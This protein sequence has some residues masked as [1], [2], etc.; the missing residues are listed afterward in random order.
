MARIRSLKP[1]FCKSES[2]AA[3][4]IPCRLHFAMLWTY[5]DDA[6]RGVDNPR[7]I[8]GELW[9][10]DDAVDLD[11]I[12]R[13]QDELN[14]KGKI[15]RYRDGDKRYFEVVNFTEHQHPN[16]PVKSSLP[17]PSCCELVVSTAQTLFENYG[18]RSTGASRGAVDGLS[19][20]TAEASVDNP[21]PLSV[22]QSYIN[23]AKNGKAS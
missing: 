6:G 22:V 14:V 9:T 1:G 2:V 4:T 16:R 8:K 21:V 15:V 19:E 12:E 3:L 13:W 11:Q 23:D 5:A 18:A 10:L 17:D 7:L 20:R